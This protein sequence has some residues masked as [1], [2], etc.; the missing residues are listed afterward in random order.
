M[1]RSFSPSSA[2]TSRTACAAAMATGLPTYVPPTALSP[3]ASMISARPMTPESGSPAAIDLAIVIRSGST[4]K[5]SMANVLPGAA[6][7][8]LH[9][10]GDQDDAVLV[11]EP[12]HALDELLRGDD[13]PALA[14]HRLEHDRR[15]VLG[16]HVRLEGELEG[17]EVVEGHAVG[18]RRERPEAGLV[19]VRLGREAECEQRPPVEASLEGDHAPPARV[20]AGELDRVL[21]RLGAGVEEAGAHLARDRGQ[22]DQALS[23]ADVVLVRDDREVG[24]GEALGLLAHRLDH[25]RMRVADV[26]AADASREVDERVPVDVGEKRAARLRDHERQVDGERLRDHPLLAGENL[27]AARAGNVCLEVDCPGRSHVRSL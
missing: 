5:C 1:A 7:A 24:V 20:G 4:P 18:L 6:E 21:D 8:G 11:A 17:V 19:G 27:G 23:Q 22:L 25:P 3:G 16:R 9:L 13:E 12:A 10:V 14:L 2:I 15:H 26:H